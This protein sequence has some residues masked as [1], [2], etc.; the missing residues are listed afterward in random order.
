MLK[1]QSSLKILELQNQIIVTSR[2]FLPNRLGFAEADFPILGS[3]EAV[4]IRL[5]WVVG[6]I[7]G[8]VEA[9]GPIL[10]FEVVDPILGFEVA[11]PI[12]AVVVVLPIL[13]VVLP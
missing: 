3:V 1:F 9:V 4:P 12:L 13:A 7:L 2:C 11:D 6:P 5:G 8:F 10:G